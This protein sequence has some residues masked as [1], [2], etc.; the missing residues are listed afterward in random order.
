L[1]GLARDFAIER[2]RV[3]VVFGLRQAYSQ[4]SESDQVSDQL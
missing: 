1:S 4:C 3:R 2:L